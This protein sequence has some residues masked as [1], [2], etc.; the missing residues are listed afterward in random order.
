MREDSSGTGAPI[1][2]QQFI[3]AGTKRLR[4]GITTGSCAAIAA[5]AATEAVLCGSFPPCAQITTPK[6]WTA[7]AEIAEQRL[8]SKN[9]ASCAVRKD[10]GDDADAT[11]GLLIFAEVRLSPEAGGGPPSVRITGG[12]GIGVVTKAGLD[13]NVGECAINAVPRAMIADAVRSVCAK[14]KFSGSADV[15]IFAPRGEEVAQNTFNPALGIRGGISILGT[16]GVVEPMSDDALAKAIEAH[17]RVIAKSL[18]DEKIRPLVIAPG[19]YGRDFASAHPVLGRLQTLACSNFVGHALDL[20]AVHGFTHVVLAGHA[21]KFVK[22]AGGVFNTHSR[23]ADCRMELIAA[24]AALCGAE[25]FDIA[26][27]LGCATVDAALSVLD[28]SGKAGIVAKSL[29]RAAMEKIARRVQKQFHFAL[30]MFTPARGIISESSTFDLSG[31]ARSAP[32]NA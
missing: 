32:R 13:Q 18:A 20:A 17:A 11:D 1:A 27:I 26:R 22:L 8:L 24:H 4:C 16:S 30:I 25:Q 29:S 2:T 7:Q 31:L 5:L 19:N 14:H 3:R 15:T 10:A 9:A 6:G 23:T 21:G 28:E 12:R